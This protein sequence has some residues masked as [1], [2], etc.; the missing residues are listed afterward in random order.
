MSKFGNFALS[1]CI[2]G[3]ALVGIT[4]TAAP[5]TVI[6]AGTGTV[7][8]AGGQAPVATVSATSGEGDSTG[9]W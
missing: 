2:T 5:G 6:A 8:M 3:A 7:S 4:A 9:W 1:V